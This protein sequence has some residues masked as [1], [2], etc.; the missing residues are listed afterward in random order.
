[1]YRNYDKALIASCDMTIRVVNP[2]IIMA[3]DTN[4][5]VLTILMNHGLA[6]GEYLLKSDAEAITDSDIYV[7]ATNSIF[8]GSKIV[9]FEEFEY[10]TNLTKIPDFCFS[11]CDRLQIIKMPESVKT[12]GLNAFQNTALTTVYIPRYVQRVDQKAFSYCKQLTS[13]VVD[14]FN[15]TYCSYGGNLYMGANPEILYMITPGLTEYVMP[16]ITTSVY[17]DGSVAWSV[18]SLLRKIVLNEKVQGV[19]G[20]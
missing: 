15:S 8:T 6:K 12:I 18:G 3:M 4:P 10:F 16:E 20:K 14:N 13:I 9:H 5:E 7:D 1:M 19:S 11:G 17:G 2:N